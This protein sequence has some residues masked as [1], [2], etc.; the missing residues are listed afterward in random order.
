MILEKIIF[1]IATM[2]LVLII[3]SLIVSFTLGNGLLL[4]LLM[5]IFFILI[6][7]VIGLIIIRVVLI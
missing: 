1:V 7:L 6:I 5:R 3:A 2:C 4:I